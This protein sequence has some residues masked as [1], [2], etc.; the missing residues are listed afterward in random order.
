MSTSHYYF[1]S[2]SAFFVFGEIGWQPPIRI[3]MASNLG[4]I[5]CTNGQK[6]DQKNEKC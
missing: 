1:I 3:F 5:L 2:N 4:I 6:I